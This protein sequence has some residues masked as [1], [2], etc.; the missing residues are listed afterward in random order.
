MDPLD[1]T[2]NFA[3]GYPSFAVSVAVLRRGVPAASTVVAF[4]G[5]PRAWHT[6]TYWAS[7]GGGAYCDDHRI[8]VSST[9]KLTNSLGVT[10]A[11]GPLLPRCLGWSAGVSLCLSVGRGRF[12]ADWP[13]PDPALAGFGYEHD[14]AW[15]ASV[16]L[17][18]HFTDVT[19]GVR[20]LGKS[21]RRLIGAGMA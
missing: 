11:C 10:G 17:F 16:D 3:H 18:R 4:T 12:F 13:S 8:R 14:E 5:G 2:T 1:G 19:R 15:S 9:A 21:L 6:R 20:R 7:R